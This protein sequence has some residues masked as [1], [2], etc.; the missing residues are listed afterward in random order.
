MDSARA[1]QQLSSVG[2]YRDAL[3][4]LA[5]S[6]AR[7]EV[8]ATELLRAELLAL[9]GECSKAQAVVDGLQ[10]HKTLSDRD[11]S[12][13][14]FVSACIAVERGSTEDEAQ[15]LHKS[16]S[17][18]ERAGDLERAC[19]AQFRLASLFADQS[20]PEAVQGLIRDFRENATKLGDASITAALHVLV[21]LIDGKRGLLEAAQ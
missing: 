8:T 5:T 14:E 19:W 1:A 2:K 18:A 12:H 21:A 17:F 15:H 13:L 6:D 20:G 3:S 7:R 16:I 10:R 4:A 9:V 11:R